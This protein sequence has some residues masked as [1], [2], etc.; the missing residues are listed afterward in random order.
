MLEKLKNIEDLVFVG[1]FAL[2]KQGLKSNYNDIDLVVTDKDFLQGLAWY[3][4]NSVYSESK[5]KAIL[6]LPELSLDIFYET[7]LPEFDIIDGFK[8]VSIEAAKKHYERIYEI[9]DFVWK[10]I[11]EEKLKIFL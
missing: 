2:C 4:S 6:I 10:P 11:I 3:R 1:G 5:E 7:K 8:C 9:A